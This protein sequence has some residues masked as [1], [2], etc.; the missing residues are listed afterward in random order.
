MTSMNAEL[1]EWLHT[2]IE[3]DEMRNAA[4]I[5]IDQLN[6]EFRLRPTW[7]KGMLEVLFAAAELCR[8]H[9]WSHGVAVGMSLM[10]SAT[11]QG[12]EPVPLDSLMAEADWAPPNIFVYSAG[13]QPWNYPGVVWKHSVELTQLGSVE[14]IRGEWFDS[15][16]QEFRRAFWVI[17]ASGEPSGAK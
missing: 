17:P 16:D 11:S 6:S 10:P 9:G 15:N 7:E 8:S 2:A 5:H 4:S 14:L 1:E 3:H 12:V 13:A